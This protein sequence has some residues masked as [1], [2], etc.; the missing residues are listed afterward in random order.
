MKHPF[1]LPIGGYGVNIMQSLNVMFMQA[2]RQNLLGICQFFFF[3]FLF[4]KTVSC[5]VTQFGVQWHDLGSLQPPPPRFKQFSCLSLLSSWDYRHAPPRPANF[6]IFSRDGVSPCW[7]G[8]SRG[9]KFL[10]T[11]WWVGGSQWASSADW[12]EMKSREVEA[13]LLH[14]VSSWV[15]AARS[16]EP[17]YQSG[18]GQLIHQVQ[19]VQNISST[20][21]RSGLRRVRILWP[22]AARLLDHNS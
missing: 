2:Q 11:T 12:S 1:N 7:P 21:L 14:W 17:V 9:A 13:V 8:W 5:S 16:D 18:W 19:G 4:L 3:C 6:C 10:R 20:D 15:G 22:P